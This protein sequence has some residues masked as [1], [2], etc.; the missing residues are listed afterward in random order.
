LG[1]VLSLF[2]DS[3][4]RDSHDPFLSSSRREESEPPPSLPP[5]PFPLTRHGERRELS[6]YFFFLSAME[7]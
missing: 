4:G 2:S 1:G 7:I 6:H 5:S 3:P